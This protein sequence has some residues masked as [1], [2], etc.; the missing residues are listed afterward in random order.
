MTRDFLYRRQIRS[1]ILI[2]AKF[3]SSSPINSDILHQDIVGCGIFC[4]VLILYVWRSK[5]LRPCNSAWKCSFRSEKPANPN[6][7][8]IP[9]RHSGSSGIP[10]IWKN[11]LELPYHTKVYL[12]PRMWYLIRRYPTWLC[13]ESDSMIWL[14]QTCRQLYFNAF[15]ADTTLPRGAAISRCTGTYLCARPLR[16]TP[17]DPAGLIQYLQ[18]RQQR[19][20]TTRIKPAT[21]RLQGPSRCHYAKH[22]PQK[23]G[24]SFAKKKK[25][26]L[27]V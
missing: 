13:I 10:G 2:V 22:Q 6:S 16:N 27:K 4:T 3:R 26:A 9:N 15:S 20:H 17:H 11:V 5:W 12:G 1:Q 7:P 19:L 23:K 14:H 8:Q 24:A 18:L 21:S 25:K